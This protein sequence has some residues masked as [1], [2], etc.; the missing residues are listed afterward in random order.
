[1][2]NV[3]ASYRISQGQVKGL[4]F[5]AGGNYV[6]D[7]WFE[8]SNTFAIPSYMLV[9]ATIFY[10]QPRYS[11]ALKGNNLLNEQYWNSNGTPQKP[12]NLIANVTFRF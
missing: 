6:S 5:G 1:V 7:S 9:N 2:A 4:G 10:S 8:A 3:W 11:V 12:V